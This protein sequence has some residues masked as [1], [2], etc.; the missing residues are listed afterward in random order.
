M[1]KQDIKDNL[2]KSRKNVTKVRNS[3]QVVDKA[4]QVCSIQMSKEG[5]DFDK[6]LSVFYLESKFYAASHTEY[7]KDS[8]ILDKGVVV[9]NWFLEHF[10]GCKQYL[11]DN[12]HLYLNPY[13][14][15]MVKMPYDLVGM[16][17][18]RL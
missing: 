16:G 8:V 4:R 6:Y 11:I 14:V 15:V 3:G 9:N 10:K 5:I 2:N 7:P 12:Q 1:G 17:L 13:T 18:V